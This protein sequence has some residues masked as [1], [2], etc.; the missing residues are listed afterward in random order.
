MAA[1]AIWAA[2]EQVKVL[3]TSAPESR[4]KF[5]DVLIPSDTQFRDKR[6][7]QPVRK[8][9]EG[10]GRSLSP[11]KKRHRATAPVSE[12][13]GYRPGQDEG[14]VLQHKNEK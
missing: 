10:R 3:L 12:P 2:V 1:S 14:D 13:S 11:V 8:E 9:E 5:F 6:L 7:E 4:C